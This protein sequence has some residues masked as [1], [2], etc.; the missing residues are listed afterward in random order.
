[1]LTSLC[2]KTFYFQRTFNSDSVKEKQTSLPGITLHLKKVYYIIK[3]TERIP[4]SC[5]ITQGINSITP[6][7]IHAYTGLGQFTLKHNTVPIHY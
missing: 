1:M 4:V 7:I 3:I 2:L 6:Q 5:D